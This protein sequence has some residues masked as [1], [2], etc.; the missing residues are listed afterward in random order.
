VRPAELVTVSGSG[1]AAHVT[2]TITFH[3]TPTIVGTAVT[4]DHGNFS[5]T[6]AVPPDA[7]AGPHHFEAVGPAGTGGGTT[8]LLAAVS[9]MSHGHHTNWLLPIAMVALTLL[10]ASFAGLVFTRSEGH[11]RP[12]VSP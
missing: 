11:L 2:V 6:V 8:T 12:P 7:P 1:F 9:V 10:L 3:S 5:V 4:D